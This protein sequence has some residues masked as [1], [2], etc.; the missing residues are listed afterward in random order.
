MRPDFRLPRELLGRFRL[1]LLNLY[2][3]I[4]TQ[5]LPPELERLVERLKRRLQK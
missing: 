5:P 1:S 2:S 4:L 3:S